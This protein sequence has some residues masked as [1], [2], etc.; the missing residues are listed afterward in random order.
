MGDGRDESG[1]VDVHPSASIAGAHLGGGVSVGADARVGFGAVIGAGTSIAVG[2]RV[3]AAAVVGVGV[4]IGAFA[5][6]ADR[7]EIQDRAEIGAHA[8]LSP[9]DPSNPS[10]SGPEGTSRGR[11]RRRPST[12]E[13]GVVIGANATI[14]PGVI[15]GKRSV[16]LP[17]SV[18]MEDVPPRAVVGGNPAVVLDYVESRTV[19]GTSAGPADWGTGRDGGSGLPGGARLLPLTRARDLRGSLSALE[20]GGLPWIPRR[21]FAVYG[22]PT[23][24]TRGEHAHHRCEQLLIAV[25]GQ[26]SVQLDDGN[27]RATVPLT[28]PDVGLLMPRRVWGRQSNFSVD[29]V[30]VVLA[31]R[32]YEPDDYIRTYEEFLSVVRSGA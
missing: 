24:E 11:A 14:L 8:V 25:N 19:R 1:T 6:I 29:A 26:L 30:L 13:K 28:S 20:F 12:V 7:V 10:D 22:V 16:V 23:A 21:F 17:G 4:T 2:A 5:D 18:V 27:H 31:S 15:L 9:I 32:P 3:G